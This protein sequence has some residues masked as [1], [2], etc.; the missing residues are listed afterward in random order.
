M[1]SLRKLFEPKS[2]ALVGVSRHPE[3]MSHWLIRNVV[4]AGFDGS[5]YPIARGEEEILGYRAYAG[6]E[7]LSGPVDLVL[8]SV[9]SKE[10]KRVIQEASGIKASVAVI[11]SSG[12]G[13]VADERGKALQE[14]IL[15]IARRSGMRV[16]GPNCLGV[17][18]GHK[19]LNG[20]F[21]AEPP[22]HKGKISLI[23][24]SGAFMGVLV[25]EMNSR[26]VGLGKF[27][28]I[29]NQTDL[30]HQEIIEY[31]GND[32]D[33]SVIGLFIEEVKDGRGFLSVVERVS[34]IKPVVIF[35]A[36]RTTA[37]RRATLTHTGSM[38]GDFAVAQAAF[39]QAGALTADTTEDFFDSLF[40]L[41]YNH[42]R[43]PKD[44]RVGIVTISG[45]PSVVATDFCGEVG[46]RVPE[47]RP[48]TQEKIRGYVP[49]F[50]AVSNPVDMTVGIPLSN[51]GPC[52][53]AL[54]SAPDISGAIALN[55]G[56]DV[57]EFA[58]AFVQARNRYGK[59]IVAFA[60]ENPK[61]QKILHKNGILNFPAP[62]RAV[63]AYRGLV[64]YERVK[65]KR[66]SR[67][68]FNSKPSRRIGEI[69][70]GKHSILN[71][72][73]SKEILSEYGVPTCK[74]WLVQ[75]VADLAEKAE[76]IGYPV[77]LKVVHAGL[78][79]KSESGGVVLNVGSE[80]DLVKAAKGLE[81]KFS[82]GVL[83][84]VQEYVKPGIEVIIGLR[85]DENYGP[86]I[87][88]GLGGIFTELLRD[89][90]LRVCPL[91]W[92]D[93]HEM[94]QEI[95][96]GALLKGYRGTPPADHD[97]LAE[98]LLRV[99]ELAV[100]NDRISEIDINPFILRGPDVKAV[101][102]LIALSSCEQA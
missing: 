2:I 60:S 72:Y 48:E 20:T 39:K 56:W 92:E 67:R 84:L 100:L 5:V 21:L 74:E 26:E 59:P 93:A 4:R 55:W 70:S 1:D 89:I 38:A 28:S 18:N 32:E 16:V 99:S 63:K 87:A 10:V 11:L 91:S 34:K 86:I 46:L 101:D 83:F 19:N 3:K 64:E 43:L 13:E 98:V 35:K 102:A 17:Y 22:A 69:E 7:Q 76:E 25:N 24:Q 61:V 30:R 97:A 78:L 75:R 45:G 49:F 53:D 82:Q 52:V 96:G 42:D 73:I 9:A 90:S 68:A 23:S 41:A 27:V 71:E 40:A 15:G 94:I 66:V 33:T 57:T 14:E 79:H 65:G 37:G 29:G 36:G 8:V 50:S 51:L 58:E 12:F 80:A 54:M 47:L 95:K 62:E 77:V 85:R 31:F 6:L 88:F 81:E 44:D